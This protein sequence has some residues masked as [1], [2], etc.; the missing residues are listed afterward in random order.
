LI[1]RGAKYSKEGAFY[2][3]EG[4]GLKGEMNVF[5]TGQLAEIWYGY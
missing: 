1:G 2:D 4:M 5:P 3:V